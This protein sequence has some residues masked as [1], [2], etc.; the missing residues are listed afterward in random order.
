MVQNLRAAAPMTANIQPVHEDGNL[1]AARERL[2]QA[3]TQLIDPHTELANGVHAEIPPL[4]M[5]L[6]DAIPGAQG[7]GHSAARSLPPIW[8]D[9]ARLYACIDT[10]VRKWQ[11]DYQ[12]CPQCK[13]CSDTLPAVRRLET[14]QNKRWRPQD[15]R[16]LEDYAGQLENWVIEIDLLLTPQH[17]WHLPNPC[18]ACDTAIVYRKDTAGDHVRQPALQ[19][20]PM[21]CECLNCHYIWGPQLFQHLANVLGYPLPSGVLQ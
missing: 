8:L 19:I 20:G 21:G 7:T 10:Q 1:P 12:H 18:P 17:K 4:I 11:T 3:I 16:L 5:Q 15:C 14:L 13:H 9:A 2:H 6:Y